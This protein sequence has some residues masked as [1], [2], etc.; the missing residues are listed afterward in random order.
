MFQ[1]R[2]L[3]VSLGETL[4]KWLRLKWQLPELRCG[5]GM[6]SGV[7]SDDAVQVKP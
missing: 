6:P 7:L 5:E 2:W 4:L 3:E 1:A